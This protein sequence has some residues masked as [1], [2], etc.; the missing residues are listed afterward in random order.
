V[1][2]EQPTE[3]R[4]GFDDGDGAPQHVPA[5]WSD[6]TWEDTGTPRGHYLRLTG[7]PLSGVKVGAVGFVDHAAAL[8]YI[9]MQKPVSVALHAH[10]ITNATTP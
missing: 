8:A 4:F 2:Q 9:S 3:A 1:L 10:T 5:S 7:N 6:A